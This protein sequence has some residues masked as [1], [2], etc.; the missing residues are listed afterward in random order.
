MTSIT[1]AAARKDQASFPPSVGGSRDSCS[2]SSFHV[3]LVSSSNCDWLSGVLL[4][5]GRAGRVLVAMMTKI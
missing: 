2:R 1:K 4:G 5:V 3:E